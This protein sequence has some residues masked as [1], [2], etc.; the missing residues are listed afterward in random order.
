MT[1]SPHPRHLRPP[2]RAGRRLQPLPHPP[3]LPQSFAGVVNGAAATRRLIRSKAIGGK[4]RHSIS[5]SYDLAT[6]IHLATYR[7]ILLQGGSASSGPP[8]VNRRF[9]CA[10][11]TRRIAASLSMRFLSTG[12]PA[13]WFP[14]VFL[15]LVGYPPDVDFAWSLYS[16]VHVR[17]FRPGTCPRYNSPMRAHTASRGLLSLRVGHR[18]VHAG[19]SQQITP[20]LR[21]TYQPHGSHLAW[22]QN[23]LRSFALNWTIDARAAAAC[24]KEY[25]EL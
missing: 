11:P 5:S 7:R 1:T 15:P 14:L 4:F 21:T 2:R 19:F 3:A 17:S 22:R 18:A 8:R 24:G 10:V 9:R 25:A 13:C 16:Y 23:R 20:C 12:P 6:S